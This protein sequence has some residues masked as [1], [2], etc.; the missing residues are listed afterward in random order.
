MTTTIQDLPKKSN[1]SDTTNIPPGD[2]KG[3]GSESCFFS[4]TFFVII[5]LIVLA[6]TILIASTTSYEGRSDYKMLIMYIL[7]MV[8]CAIIIL[9]RGAV[10]WAFKIA[11]LIPFFM[12]FAMGLMAAII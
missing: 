7:T 12:Y 4:C 8:L 5:A 2:K 3:R 9:G 11:V 10:H 1:E 6:I